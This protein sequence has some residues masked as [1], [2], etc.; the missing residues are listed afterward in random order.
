[1]QSID[2][3]EEIFGPEEM[4]L[5]ETDKA[6]IRQEIHSTHSVWDKIRGWSPL[7]AVVA[8]FLFGLNQWS[9]YIEFRTTTGERLKTIE[10]ALGIVQL[11]QLSN[12]PINPANAVAAQKILINAQSEKLLLDATAVKNSGSAFLKASQENPSAWD[13]V[14]SFLNYRAFLNEGSFPIA[15][16]EFSPVNNGELISYAEVSLKGPLTLKADFSNQL[17]PINKAFIYQK[18]DEAVQRTTGHP[19]LLIHAQGP[20]YIQLDGSWIR[21]VIF[22]G[23]RIHYEGG[24]LILQDVY[25]I[26]CTF[27]IKQTS[28][29]Q[30]LSARLM[31][32]APTNYSQPSS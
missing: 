28:N 13:A 11:G 18:I 21:K 8:I 6:W 29:S 23:V 2:A 19:Y 1:M 25:F 20:G 10:S 26:N 31:E 14:L 30:V 12:N 9:G 3:A 27:D 5:N 22:E 17:V 15:R 16:K 7:A 24:P 32:P 4:P